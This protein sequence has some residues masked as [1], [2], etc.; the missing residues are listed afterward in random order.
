[1]A[2]L[3]DTQL[4]LWAAVEPERLSAKAS[5]LLRDRREHIAFSLASI[6]EIAIKTSLKRPDFSVDP[7]ALHS[8]LLAAGFAELALA[9]KHLFRV[10]TL[11]WVHRDPFDR[12]L[13]AQAIEEGM[14]LLSVDA[15]MKGYGKFVKAV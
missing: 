5:K 3:L 6:W 14:T 4:V 11:P 9:P 8:G 10:A 12:L 7:A 1:V 2:Y 13:V 15:A